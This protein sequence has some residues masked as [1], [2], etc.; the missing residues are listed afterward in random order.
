MY[1]AGRY[2]D[3]LDDEE[4]LSKYYR[5]DRRVIVI[6]RE[7]DYESLPGEIKGEV[8]AVVPFKVGHKEMVITSNDSLRLLSQKDLP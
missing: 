4:A 8:K 5:E 2:I 7:E 6:M 3:D 1:Y